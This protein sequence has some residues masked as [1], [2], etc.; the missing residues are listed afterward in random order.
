M[1]KILMVG[2]VPPPTGGIAS[3]M[4]DIIHSELASEFSF[5]LF[6]RHDFQ[7]RI[8]RT[9]P[10]NIGRI[11]QFVNFF[12][13][14]W[15]GNYYLVQIHSSE[16]AFRGTI[17][18]ILLSR[19]A[20]TDVLLHMHGADWD[21]FYTRRSA[22]GRL[23]IWI[24]LRIA[25]HI[26][27]L[28]SRWAENIR[29]LCPIANVLV[30]RNLI[31]DQDPPDPS[32]VQQMKEQLG[33]TEEHFVVLTIG[34]VGWNKGNFVILNAIPQV[35]SQDQ[36]IRFVLVGSEEMPGEMAQLMEQVRK[37]NLGSWVTFTGEVER[38]KTALFYSFA[39]AYLLP[40]FTEGMPISIIEAL[41]SGLPVIS[42]RVG[43]IPDMIEDHVSGLL[44]N[45]GAPNEIA[46]A[47]LLLRKDQR[48]RKKLA[49]GARRTFEDK[50]EFSR[51]IEEIRAAYGSFEKHALK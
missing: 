49:E 28:Y 6:P 12:L 18:F 27:V 13:K 16:G 4:E 45:P 32:K 26:V 7:L 5:E 47:V 48:L 36:S 31:H 42:T 8:T 2:P 50:F 3:V 46:E 35:V 40:S 25:P 11:K 23:Y 10:R 21:R 20:R 37:E 33:L 51:G 1:K 30:I 29:K 17:L 39:D 41:R 14:L 43:G 24:G 44:L 22:F 9:I 34:Y 15:C 38:N 19:L